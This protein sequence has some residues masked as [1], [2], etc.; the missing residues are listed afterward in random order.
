M[1]LNWAREEMEEGLAFR[2]THVFGQMR[3]VNAILPSGDGRAA[4]MEMLKA[5]VGMRE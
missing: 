4:Q 5:F 3:M 2:F 1:L